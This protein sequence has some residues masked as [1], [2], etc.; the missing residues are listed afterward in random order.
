MKLTE[1]IKNRK[2]YSIIEMLITIA[3]M[4][5]VMT[6][7]Y[8]ALLNGY[9]LFHNESNYQNVVSDVQIFYDQLNTRVR[10]S[11]F[12]DTEIISTVSRLNEFEGVKELAPVDVIHVLRIANVF[13]YFKDESMYIYN[14]SER[15]LFDHVTSFLI[16]ET[17]DGQIVTIN[18]TINVEG[19]HETISTL[20]Y[21]RY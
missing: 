8:L 12:K 5:F 9:E 20:I 4:S 10:L 21:E 16:E 13:Y 6:P 14:K 2:A 19:R 11:G 3:I 15:K 7:A 1:K 18:T 17:S